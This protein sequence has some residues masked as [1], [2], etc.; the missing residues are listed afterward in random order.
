MKYLLIP[1]FLFPSV[2]MAAGLT[3]D[4]IVAIAGLLRAF[5]VPSDVVFHVENILRGP[6]DGHKSLEIT[7]VS[8]VRPEYVGAL[9]GVFSF[10]TN[11]PT[12]SKVNLYASSTFV[13]TYYPPVQYREN[14]VV[15]L[16]GLKPYMD[17]TAL[18]TVEHLGEIVSTSTTFRL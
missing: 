12:Y 5:Q 17:Y 1:L 18:I 16:P 4:Q 7:D 2:S 14:P 9:G 13:G 11:Y 10:S 6:S 3:G 8:M 15:H